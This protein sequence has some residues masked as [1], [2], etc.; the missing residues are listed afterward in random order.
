LSEAVHPFLRVGGIILAAG[1]STRMGRLKQL[2]PFGGGTL[3][4]HVIDTALDAALGPVVV[5]IGAEA[6]EVE[7]A[8]A[9]KDI[10][11]ARNE[12]WR[13][14]MGSSIRAG[15]RAIEESGEK[16]DAVAILL[17]DQPNITA[18]HLSQMRSRL[19][20]SGARIVAAE[21]GGSVGAPAFFLRDLFPLLASLPPEAGAKAMLKGAAHVEHF[22]L[23]E[24]AFDVD[25]PED[26]D[27]LRGN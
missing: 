11:V 13:S 26:Y 20:S 7:Q 25:T 1:A 15:L 17:A 14:G 27:S 24:A 3:L 22:P 18:R 16:C 10:L 5:V 19:Q 9:H 8:I 12:N 2:M 21:Y 6:D 4:W 23:P